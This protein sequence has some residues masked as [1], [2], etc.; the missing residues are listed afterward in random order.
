MDLDRLSER[1][2]TFAEVECADQPLYA[3]LCNGLATHRPLL[4]DLLLAAPGQWRPSLLLAA[5]HDLV[6]R[7][8]REPFARLYPSVGGAFDR[9]TDPMELLEPFVAGHRDELSSILTT[10]SIQTNEPNRS[11][12]WW[13]AWRAAAADVADLPISLVELGPSAGLN[14]VA[15]RYRIAF[16]DT[17]RG[18]P[19]SPVRLACELRNG[20]RWLDAPSPD[21]VERV[22]LDTDPV[23]LADPDGLRWLRACLWPE[24]PERRSRFDD[25]VSRFLADPDPPTMLGGNAATDLAALLA[26]LRDDT[27]VVVYNS[28]AMTYLPRDRR[29]VVEAT[30]AALGSTRP[31]T[32][33]SAEA[34]GVLDWIP[35][36]PA[37]VSLAHTVVGMARW[38]DGVRRDERRTLPSASRLARMVRPTAALTPSPLRRWAP[39][40]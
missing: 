40:P 9:D 30:L 21:I 7:F 18:D 10:R 6:M 24:Q 16:G 32:W 3:A 20:R 19:A 12:L 15:D 28:W 36:D 27:H 14:L 1:F 17:V 29:P 26:G 34:D 38:R 2:V 13:I 11:C 5:L 23:D 35:A 37:G 39:S 33:I 31:V 8:P 22:G 25:A 4:A